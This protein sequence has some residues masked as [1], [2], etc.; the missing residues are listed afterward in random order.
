MGIE[1]FS[2][3][4]TSTN[5]Q[6]NHFQ[7]RFVEQR[8]KH[9]STETTCSHC[10]IKS[11][12]SKN[13]SDCCGPKLRQRRVSRASKAVPA[14]SVALGSQAVSVASGRRKTL[15]L[16]R[17]NKNHIKFICQNLLQLISPGGV[18]PIKKTICLRLFSYTVST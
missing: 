6:R 3:P 15:F 4:V 12:P 18:S 10:Q 13:M 9:F 8:D 5:V 2:L 14:Q 7:L 1:K 11:Y 17:D 16:S